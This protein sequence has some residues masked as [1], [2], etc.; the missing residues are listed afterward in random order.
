MKGIQHAGEKISLYSVVYWA[1]DTRVTY[2]NIFRRSDAA[3]P[4]SNHKWPVVWVKQKSRIHSP[5]DHKCLVRKE[6]LKT[7]GKS[8]FHISTTTRRCNLAVLY[9]FLYWSEWRRNAIQVLIVDTSLACKMWDIMWV[10]RE[11]KTKLFCDE[12]SIMVVFVLQEYSDYVL[13]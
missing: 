8:H 6:F 5:S 3:S 9:V 7:N 2:S 13:L 1:A 4:P 11:G 12:E 10:R